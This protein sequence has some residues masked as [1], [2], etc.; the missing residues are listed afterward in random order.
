V[1]DRLAIGCERVLVEP[2]NRRFRH[3]VPAEPDVTPTDRDR[4]VCEW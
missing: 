1:I 4:R 3:D 2:R